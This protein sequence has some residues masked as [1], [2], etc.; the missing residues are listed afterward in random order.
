MSRRTGGLIALWLLAVLVSVA[1]AAQ[2]DPDVVIFY[3]EGCHDCERIDQVLQEL[4]EQFP[5]LEIRYIEEGGPQGD[6]MWAL[7]SEYGIFPTKFPVV[8]VG[9]EAITGVGLDKELRLR[10][11]VEVCMR[12]GCPSPLARVTG[13][14]VPWRTYVVAGLIAVFLLLV[15]IDSAF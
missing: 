10:A 8:F 13:P 1:A 11:A 3:R 14:D 2:S 5:A 7:S 15:V 4:H 12:S 9:N 6:L